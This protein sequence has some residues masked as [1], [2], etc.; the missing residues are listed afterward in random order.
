MKLIAGNL[1]FAE[2][3]VFKGFFVNWMFVAIIFLTFGVQLIFVEFGG[4]PIKC[5]PLEMKYHIICIGLGIVGLVYGVIVRICVTCYR[6]RAM[7]RSSR[8]E[9]HDHEEESKALL[10]N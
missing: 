6:R 2:I 7:L 9:S 1:S 8:K 3:N 10:G 5:A 4:E